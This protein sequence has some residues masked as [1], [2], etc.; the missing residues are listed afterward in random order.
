MIPTPG[1]NDHD[2][3]LDEV[4]F[5]FT[6][7]GHADDAFA[8]LRM[9]L[10]EPLGDLYEGTFELV[11]DEFDIAPQSLLEQPAC[12]TLRRAHRERRFHGV[13]RRVEDLG[14]QDVGGGPVSV[15]K[16]V[17]RVWLVPRLWLL[18]QRVDCRIYQEL[19]ATEVFL[20]VI[21]RT[22]V[23]EVGAIDLSQMATERAPIEYVVQYN[24]S[25]LDFLRRLSQREGFW[26]RFVQ[27]DDAET[28]AL[29]DGGRE[30]ELPDVAADDGMIVPV[31]GRSLDTAHVEGVRSVEWHRSVVPTRVVVGD[32]DLTRPQYRVRG[33]RP[34]AGDGRRE[35][36]RHPGPARF[37]GYNGSVYEGDD[38]AHLAGLHYAAASAD[39]L[40][41][42]GTGN[43]LGF[44]AGN[45]FR[46]S[47]QPSKRYVLTH[48]EHEGEAPELLLREDDAARGERYRNTF[49]CLDATKALALAEVTPKPLIPGPQTATVVGPP[50]EDIYTDEHG[51]IKVQFHWDR[52]GASDE[53]STCWLRAAQAWGGGAFGAQF[54]PRAGMEVVVCFLDGDPDRPLAIGCVYPQTYDWPFL[55][56]GHKNRAGVRTNTVGKSPMDRR[57]NELS[58]DDTPDHEEV[59]VHASRNLREEVGHDRRRFVGNDESVSVER[60][61]SV[62]VKQDHAISAER[63]GTVTVGRD[64]AVYVGGIQSRQVLGNDNTVI[65]GDRCVDL[66]NVGGAVSAGDLPA[67][68]NETTLMRGNR[69]V[70]VGGDSTEEVRGEYSLTVDKKVT[71]RVGGS[72][73]TIEPGK[74]TLTSTEIEITTPTSSLTLGA[75]AELKGVTVKFNL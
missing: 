21:R 20:D 53:R 38:A 42:E 17:L 2:G 72:E 32:H 23:Y 48:V 36:F 39:A 6:V 3:A 46:L 67:T 62:H 11:T 66:G 65:V 28:V 47:H 40:T 69:K 49:R 31:L 68:G 51:R 37:S 22:G 4:G 55:P 43:V 27:G 24:E 13:V 54:I 50:G 57:Y 9:Q 18:S 41:G 74:I 52:H 56:P 12:A 25:D 7:K 10:V 26:M 16:R 73:L 60:D 5:E 14:V 30:T 71:V 44:G 33:Q 70:D 61:Q 75:D 63:D 19:T 8:V 15:A 45:D 58:F 59:F 64:R 29:H 35:V 1:M 34:G